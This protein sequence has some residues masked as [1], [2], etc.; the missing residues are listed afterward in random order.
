MKTYTCPR[1]GHTTDQKNNLRKHFL[2]KNTCSNKYDDISIEECFKTILFEEKQSDN[3]STTFFDCRDNISTTFLNC[4][5]NNDNILTTFKNSSNSSYECLYCNKKFSH[6][7]SKNVHMK[8]CKKL[9]KESEDFLQI[10]E[11]K[12]EIEK[13]K[14]RIEKT[15][16]SKN[17]YGNQTITNNI[18]NNFY[19]NALGKENIDYISKEYIHAIVNDG[20]YGSIQKLIK[21][22]HFNPKHKENQNIRIP[23]KKDK[24]ALVYNGNKWVMENKMNVITQVTENAYDIIT[25]HCMDLHNRKFDKFCDEFDRRENSCRKRVNGDTELLILNNQ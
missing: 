5:D 9:K 17:I 14:S 12:D 24:F 20:P 22:I 16:T 8:K 19:I 3:I 1:C 23:N 11:L 7:N 6:R 18:Q 25:D 13:L 21:H 4:R 2:R 15:E 10:S